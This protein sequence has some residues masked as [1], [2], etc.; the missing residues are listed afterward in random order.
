MKRHLLIVVLALVSPCFGVAQSATKPPAK[1][2]T[3]FRPK[4]AAVP[5]G[6]KPAAGKTIVRDGVTLYYEVYGQGEPLLMIHGNGGSIGT[7][8][9]QIAFFCSRYRVIA[10]DS[11]YTGK[12]GERPHR[13]D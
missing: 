12:A 5:Y 3:A 10:L 8:A 2:A 4:V 9:A 7:L 11:R 6:A 13:I 1:V